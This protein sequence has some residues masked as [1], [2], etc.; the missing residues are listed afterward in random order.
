MVLSGF[1]FDPSHQSVYRWAEQ[2]GNQ[3]EHK[4]EFVPSYC[5]HRLARKRAEQER[6]YSEPKSLVHGSLQHRHFYAVTFHRFDSFVIPC[7]RM[8]DHAHAGIRR[9]DS[10]QS[11]RGF[12]RP[13]R[14]DHLSGML[15]VA[16]ADPAAVMERDP[17]RAA[18]RVD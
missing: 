14:H 9:E 13:I 2:D 6:E 7:I 18:D 16:H 8:P 10:F 4:Q 1:A 12:R 3:E 11:P 5:D 15:A 17:C